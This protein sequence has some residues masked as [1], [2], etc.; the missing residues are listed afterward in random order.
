MAA[1]VI[2]DFSPLFVDSTNTIVP[3]VASWNLGVTNINTALGAPNN[4][5][6]A[7]QTVFRGDGSLLTGI[8]GT[9]TLQDTYDLGTNILVAGSTP[10]QIRD[11]GIA[12]TD[13]SLGIFP[14]LF[15]DIEQ[16][17]LALT[18]IGD[19]TGAIPPNAGGQQVILDTTVSFP[20]AD[21][22][23]FGVDLSVVGGS[24]IN[25]AAV[26]GVTSFFINGCIMIL[27][28]CDV[29]ADDGVYTVINLTNGGA[30]NS[31]VTVVDALTQAPATF[32]STTG[33]AKLFNQV[34]GFGAQGDG[35]NNSFLNLANGDGDG[36]QFGIF[37][38]SGNV[39][40]Q[41]Q[42]FNIGDMQG[43]MFQL[44]N[45][46][47]A[48]GSGFAD[49][50]FLAFGTFGVAPDR[51]DMQWVARPADPTPVNVYGPAT[52]VSFTDGS[53]DD[54]FITV[55]GG[56]AQA[57]GIKGSM[58]ITITGSASNNITERVNRI[59]TNSAGDE[60]IVLD[61]SGTLTNEA[62]GA[63][64][65]I[66]GINLEPGMEWYNLSSL[67]G[68]KKI[69]NGTTTEE[70]AY[71]SDIA[72]GGGTLD[73]AYDFGGAGLG[74]FI[75][76]DSGAVEITIPDTTATPGLT[77]VNN[78]STSNP[79]SL[80]FSGAST[81]ALISAANFTVSQSGTVGASSGLF[82]DT[83]SLQLGS[84]STNNGT[85]AFFNAT[86]GNNVSI[87]SGATASS[88]GYI[89]P[90][91]QGATNTVL[92]NDGSGNLSWDPVSGVVPEVLV[93][94]SGGDFTSVDAAI[95]A[96]SSGPT[97]KIRVEGTVSEPAST[98][99]TIPAAVHVEITLAPNC[100][101]TI[102][103]DTYFTS[104]NTG[105]ITIQGEYPVGNSSSDP[106]MIVNYT[107]RT[108][109]VIEW[110]GTGISNST[111]NI[112]NIILNFTGSTTNFSGFTNSANQY[113]E[114]LEWDLGNNN[115]QGIIGGTNALHLTNI[116]VVG[117]GVSCTNFLAA[118]SPQ[119]VVISTLE[120]QGPFQ[121]GGFIMTFNNNTYAE[122]LTFNHNNN[123]V[124]DMGNAFVRGVKN[125]G[126]S[127][128][129]LLGGSGSY[130]DIN[131]ISFIEITSGLQG[132]RYSDCSVNQLTNTSGVD[133]QFTNCEF[134]TLVATGNSINHQ[135]FS[136]CIFYS[137][138]TC[139][140]DNVKYSNC[141]FGP[142]TGGTTDTLTILGNA[143]NT[144]VSNCST[145]DAG[146]IVDGGTGTVGGANTTY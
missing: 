111:V 70:F 79:A 74:R 59:Y 106:S 24:V 1:P 32:T 71:L 66:T 142:N 110:S 120:L 101:W 44:I 63:S 146:G 119:E 129:E 73:D 87:A 38:D 43:A 3:K 41:L 145:D 130:S 104:A 108:S 131:G 61:S 53:P 23:D 58:S 94:A 65:T 67:P 144:Q 113:Y 46:S 68:R 36:G 88:H 40:A 13:G 105:W 95:A 76:A 96:Y 35:P 6:E 30:T 18:F 135:F 140:G 138:A 2:Q 115:G 117:G 114:N 26:P 25:R 17:G 50:C 12:A 37:N 54:D 45:G 134:F 10:V 69:F 99:I 86:N 52:N 8:G 34:Y 27:K 136:N 78:D 116:L 103:D 75:T 16:G 109:Q 11:N 7:G 137:G 124:V 122:N 126:G 83:V 82:S 90:T 48:F 89:L 80:T 102:P 107:T 123:I 64:V 139:D 127:F 118:G 4:I 20:G 28:G 92:T 62:A 56:G 72:G 77:I 42:S 29:P 125:P 93:A 60:I 97:Y 31:V 5:G 141:R 143:N 85:I 81:G 133:N 15:V 14:G 57:A 47:P 128:V 19:G 33:E 21:Q 49:Q 112:K 98:A 91:A 39:G 22:A 100:D 9:Q 121:A 84:A 132:G 55:V 51:G